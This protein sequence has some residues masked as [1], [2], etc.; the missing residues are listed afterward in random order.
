MKAY[1]PDLRERVLAEV[2]AG[3]QSQAQIA[4]HFKIG[5]ST[6]EGWLRR[7]RATGSCAALPHGGGRPRAL[8]DCVR[9]L[10]DELKRH[11]D[12]TLEELCARVAEVEGVQANPSM[13]C[14]ELQRLKLP[15]KKRRFTIASGTRRGSDASAGSSTPRFASRRAG[16]W[17]T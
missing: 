11:P 13:M 16:C 17:A 10:R 5:L 14:R 9:F 12:A 1:S 7:Q 4:Q 8:Q 3:E 15:R 2:E 6:L